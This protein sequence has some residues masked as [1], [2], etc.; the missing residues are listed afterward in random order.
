M[1]F[2]FSSTVEFIAATL[3]ARGAVEDEQVLSAFDKLDVDNT[4][5]ISKKNICTILGKECSIKNC[6]GIV[7]DLIAEVD[8]NNDGLISYD[9]FL[10]LFRQ[11]SRDGP[12][13]GCGC[14]PKEDA[15]VATT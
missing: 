15:K 3:E 11:K 12:E 9:E 4:G 8:T 10:Q 6:D 14:Q 13:I 5:Y 7:N 2:F 1:R